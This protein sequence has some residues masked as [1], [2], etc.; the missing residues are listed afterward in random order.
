[1]T[2]INPLNKVIFLTCF[3]VLYSAFFTSS[4]AQNKPKQQ[5]HIRMGIYHNP[6]LEYYKNGVASGLYPEILG[7]LS[8]KYNWK[9][10]YVFGSWDS[11]YNTLLKGNIDLM[12]NII[13]LPEHDSLIDFNKEPLLT[14]WGEL[15]IA[16]DSNIEHLSDLKNK[17]IGVLKGGTN[18]IAFK[19]TAS[20][21]GVNLS[22]KNYPDYESII[23]AIE[24]K[25]VDAGVINNFVG[26]SLSK[27]YFIK[28]S[29]IVFAPNHLLFATKKGRNADILTK[30]DKTLKAWKAN[31]DSFYYNEID[32]WIAKVPKKSFNYQLLLNIVFVLS[33]II[34]IGVVWVYTLRRQVKK[35]YAKFEKSQQ[36]LILSQKSA[37]MAFL[38]WDLKTDL[39][40]T[41]PEINKLYGLN[42]T[43]PTM[44]GDFI[45]DIVHPDDA[46]KVKKALQKAITKRIPYNIEHRNIR[47]SDG[48]VFWVHTI[49]DLS[50]DED[51]TPEELIGTVIDITSLKTAEAE[52]LDNRNRLNRAEKSAQLG[53]WVLDLETKKINLSNGAKLVTGFDS[54]EITLKEFEA[55][56]NELDKKKFEVLFNNTVFIDNEALSIEIRFKNLKTKRVRNLLNHG[57]YDAE[58][59][60]IYVVLQD[61][62]DKRKLERN[63]I[64]AFVE[65]Q[66]IEKQA[67]GEELHDGISQI[68]AAEAMYIDVLM[69]LDKGTDEKTTDFLSKIRELNLSATNE[70]RNI[71]HGLMSK[72]LKEKGFL[73]AIEHICIDYSNSKN[74]KFSF[75]CKGVKED[76]IDKEIKTNLYRITQEVSTNITRHSLAKKASISISKKNKTL[77]KLE[78]KD[79]GVGIDFDKIKRENKGTGLKN[80]ERRVSLLNGRVTV[81]SAPNKGTC[82]TIVVPL[83]EVK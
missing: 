39:I 45:R 49:A 48:S 63:F 2:K 26:Y 47:P 79:N 24:D 78:I 25:E 32:V 72:I 14:M 41:S 70:A 68:L 40:E 18:G 37:G 8:K 44:S 29:N 35:A 43:K 1:M 77:L 83:N 53:N 66:E 51:G 15:F 71:A 74:I 61:V 9:I 56:I 4:S 52:I 23:R 22:F 33:V 59:K 69:K 31:K 38:F 6:P 12:N 5:R 30:I 28:N 67:F 36:K 60:K 13:Y 57:I 10:D 54:N 65:A 55:A 46:A 58:T 20:D 27:N 34:F 82:Y 7:E 75:T 62:S 80:I 11:L 73:K 19:K 64:S 50:Y 76:E 21:F 3:F 42:E 81:D 17:K 16:Q